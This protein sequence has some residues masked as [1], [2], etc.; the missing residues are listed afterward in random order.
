MKMLKEE[1]AR[2]EA[3]GELNRPQRNTEE[4]G[5]EVTPEDVQVDIPIEEPQG[6][7]SQW[8]PAAV[9]GW[10]STLGLGDG[11]DFARLVSAAGGDVAVSLP[12]SFVSSN[13]L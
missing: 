6:P 8:S 13:F 10:L 12:V 7:V 1:I 9:Q 2:R 3:G 5:E 4:Y 11:S